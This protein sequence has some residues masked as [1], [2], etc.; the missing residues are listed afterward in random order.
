MGVFPTLESRL[1]LSFLDDDDEALTRLHFILFGNGG[2]R[3]NRKRQI[4]LWRPGSSEC[5][6]KKPQIQRELGET[7]GSVLKEICV[8]LGL[9]IG[10]DRAQN[11]DNILRVLTLSGFDKKN[12]SPRQVDFEKSTQSAPTKPNDE[13]SSHPRRR[14]GRPRK[15]NAN[16]ALVQFLKRRHP[17]VFSEWEQMDTVIKETFDVDTGNEDVR[18]ISMKDDTRPHEVITEQT[19]NEVVV[20]PRGRPR[21]NPPIQ[22]PARRRGRPRKTGHTSSSSVENPIKKRGRPRKIETIERPRKILTGKRGRP[23]KVIEPDISQNVP[24]K[25]GRGRPR[26]IIRGG[27]GRPRKNI[28]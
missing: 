6:I 28:S 12:K 25:R 11:E 15:Y 23:K 14:Q 9:E 26:K 2:S 22:G 8:I 1:N 20:R 18:D 19:A 24:L 27:P 13:L 10:L 3:S 17:L 21:K 5:Q 7:L 16:R 4:G